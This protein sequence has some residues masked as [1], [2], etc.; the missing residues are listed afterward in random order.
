MEKTALG[1]TTLAARL[2]CY[3]TNGVLTVPRGYVRAHKERAVMFWWMNLNDTLRIV[4]HM[5]AQARTPVHR[6]ID[7]LEV[8]ECCALMDAI[9]RGEGTSK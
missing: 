6:E 9:E 3:Y 8:Q 4:R 2:R 5:Q 7:E 1:N